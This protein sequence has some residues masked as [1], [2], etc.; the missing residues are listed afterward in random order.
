MLFPPTL[1]STTHAI[2]SVVLSAGILQLNFHRPSG[3]MLEA[4]ERN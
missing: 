4:A 1:V 3:D 2:A